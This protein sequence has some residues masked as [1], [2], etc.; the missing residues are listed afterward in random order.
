VALL[1]AE[2]LRRNSGF[3]ARTAKIDMAAMPQ[4]TCSRLLRLVRSPL[5]RLYGETIIA[6]HHISQTGKAE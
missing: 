1:S 4:A 2:R 6:L 5:T 3:P